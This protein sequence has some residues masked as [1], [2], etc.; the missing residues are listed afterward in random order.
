M[1]VALRPARAADLPALVSVLVAAWRGGYRGVVPDEV[2][3][4]L[5]PD[6][7]AGWLGAGVDDAS[8]S[9]VVAVVDGAAAGFVRFGADPDQPDPAAGYVAALYVDPRAGGRGV[10]SRLLAHALAELQRAGRADVRLWVFEANDRARGLYQRAGFRP[11]GARTTDPRWRTPQIRLRRAPRNTAVPL[12]PLPDVQLAAVER[13]EVTRVH[14]PLRRPFRT[15]LREVRELAGWRVALT[16]ADGWTA[17][18]TT[19]AT[20]QITGDTDVSIDTALAGPLRDAVT[21]G[22]PAAEVLDAVAAAGAGTPSAAA[23]VD[24]A[25]HGLVAAVL[26]R[27]VVEVLGGSRPGTAASVVTVAVD[28]PTAMA[29]AAADLVTEGVPGL[30]LKL[31]DASLDVARVLAVRERVTGH[32]VGLRI[33]ANQ[34]WTPAEAL[35]VLEA[36]HAADVALE[37]VEQPVAAA[38]LNGLA[39]VTAHS[40]Y[41]VMADESVFTADDIRR[42]ADAGAADLVNLKLLK[43]GGLHPARAMVAA[44]AEAGL[45]LLVGCMLEPEDGVAAAA[46]L[47]SVASAGPLA[48][49]LDA[50]WWLGVPTPRA[51]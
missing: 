30:K 45:G 13:F 11:D 9:T 8:F 50:P 16:T 23:A 27:S 37:L 44:C 5:D 38:D 40:P 19:V 24:V 33:D 21:G 22:G 34:A 32:P 25:V 46:A 28:S 2:I 6:T 43:C 3:D 49:D 47:A 14:R 12:A 18:G 48:H 15:A 4:A 17:S 31:S 29:D 41:P 26:G 39:S 36:L 10:G 35:A 1:T 20:P 42:I 7:V 51:R